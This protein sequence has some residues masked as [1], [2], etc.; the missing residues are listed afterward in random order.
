M[1]HTSFVLHQRAEQDIQNILKT[2]IPF[3]TKNF[4][5]RKAAVMAWFRENTSFVANRFLDDRIDLRG[6]IQ[7]VV[8]DLLERFRQYETHRTFGMSVD[9]ANWQVGIN[10]R[11]VKVYESNRASA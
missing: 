8:T 5:A 2:E 7:K 3:D 11:Y 4:A 1:N 6:A 9:D 10:T